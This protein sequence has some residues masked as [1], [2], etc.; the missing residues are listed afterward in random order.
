MIDTPCESN[1]VVEEDV[2][3]E[4]VHSDVVDDEI[5]STSQA[6]KQIEII[7]EVILPEVSELNVSVM[8]KKQGDK[9][10]FSPEKRLS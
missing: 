7:P 3:P 6:V 5:P 2:S 8:T 9:I 1:I 4:N 10:E